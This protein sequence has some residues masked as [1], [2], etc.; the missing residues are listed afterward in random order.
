VL[1]SPDVILPLDGLLPRARAT[2][3]HS[4]LTASLKTGPR[5]IENMQSQLGIG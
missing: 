3:Y 2:V 4:L 1:V 5:L